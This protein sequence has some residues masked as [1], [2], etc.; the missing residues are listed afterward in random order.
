MTISRQQVELVRR[1]AG[2]AC[3]YCGV[4][5]TDS[6]GQLTVDHFQPLGR[7]GSDEAENLV[8]A[9][10][11]CNLYKGGYWPDGPSSPHLWKPRSEPITLHMRV[12]ADGI[13]VP[14]SPQG[15]WTIERL[16]LNRPGLVAYR[17]RRLAWGEERLLRQR[18]RALAQLLESYQQEESGLHSDQRRA[19]GI[20]TDLLSDFI[21]RTDQLGPGEDK[22]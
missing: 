3:E 19:L 2:Y 22:T 6:G 14:L 5:E 15:E 16:R 12:G 18:T 1:Q 13:L 7:G 4:S 11:R 8:Y 20:L 9:C 21:A 17:Q 10:F